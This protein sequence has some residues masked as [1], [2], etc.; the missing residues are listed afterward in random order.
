MTSQTSVQVV[1]SVAVDTLKSLLPT[2]IIGASAQSMNPTTLAL[3]TLLPAFVQAA[4]TMKAAG[5]SSPEQ[6]ATIFSAVSASVQSDH[7]EFIARQAARSASVPATIA[8]QAA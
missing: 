6:L 8:N 5:N 1:S 2:I 3:L 7:D 4:E